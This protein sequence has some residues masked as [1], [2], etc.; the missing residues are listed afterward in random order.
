AQAAGAPRPAEAVAE[1]AEDLAPMPRDYRALVQLF[2]DRREGALYGHLYGAVHLVRMEPG[3]LELRPTPMAPNN[4]ANRVGQLL[5]E[6]TGQR[7]VAMVSTRPGEPTLAEQDDAEVRRAYAEAEANPVVRAVL[8]T[9]DGARIVDVRDLAK[10]A[11]E[12]Q[13]AA[14]VADEPDSDD[15]NIRDALLYPLDEIGDE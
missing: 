4:L 7:W 5:T 12:A 10:A 14:Q 13:A 11:A 6:W 8:S 15:I 2:A 9:F 3:R 1:G